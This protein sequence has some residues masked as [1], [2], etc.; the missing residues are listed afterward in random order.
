[1]PPTYEDICDGGTKESTFVTAPD[2]GDMPAIAAL[3][4]YFYTGEIVVSKRNYQVLGC[5]HK[6]SCTVLKIIFKMATVH[7]MVCCFF[8]KLKTWK[9]NESPGD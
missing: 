8:R 3:A 5:K 9:Q 1:M 6:K 7:A 2:I 4:A